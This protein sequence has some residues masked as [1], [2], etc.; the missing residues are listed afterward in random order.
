MLMFS[1]MLRYLARKDMNSFHRAPF[2]F[3]LHFGLLQG[4]LNLMPPMTQSGDAG[5]HNDGSHCAP[6]SQ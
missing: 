3:H 1:A 6:Q 4:R 2:Q 5:N